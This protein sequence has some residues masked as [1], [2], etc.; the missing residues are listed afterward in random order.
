VEAPIYGSGILCTNDM[1]I[2]STVFG[3][4]I[5][6][7]PFKVCINFSSIAFL[8]ISAASQIYFCFS[9]ARQLGAVNVFQ[10]VFSRRLGSLTSCF[11]IRNVSRIVAEFCNSFL[12]VEQES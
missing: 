11:R 6:L 8:L 7:V 1:R 2:L 12:K 3:M 5:A 9:P 4:E 10:V